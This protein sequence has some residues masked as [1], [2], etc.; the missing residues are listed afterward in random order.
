MTYRLQ[1]KN[2]NFLILMWINGRQSCL[3]EKKKRVPIKK[4]NIWRMG[5]TLKNAT[6]K[7]HVTFRCNTIWAPNMVMDSENHHGN[8][9]PGH[10][11]THC[12]LFSCCQPTQPR[13]LCSH[14]L[15]SV[16]VAQ[17]VSTCFLLDYRAS[18]LLPDPSNSSARCS[19]DNR[20]CW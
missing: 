18:L 10:L 3:E 11:G 16:Q 17:W 20:S 14:G 8:G 7:K 9:L 4:R 15:L 19:E 2:I 6:W 13:P 5:W 1:L 12:I